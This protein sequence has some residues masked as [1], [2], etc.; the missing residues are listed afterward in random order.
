MVL[1]QISRWTSNFSASSTV[2]AIRLS[3]LTFSVISGNIFDS[4][5]WKARS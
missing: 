2:T 3:L 4:S 5:K 1:Y